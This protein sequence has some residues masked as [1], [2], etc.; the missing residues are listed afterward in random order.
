MFFPPI[1]PSAY[2]PP[3]P[4]R[5]LRDPIGPNERSL[6]PKGAHRGL[7]S[8]QCPPD[9]DRLARHSGLNNTPHGAPNCKLLRQ[10]TKQWLMWRDEAKMG[11]LR[12]VRQWHLAKP[13]ETYANCS[14]LP[15]KKV[16][17]KERRICMRETAK[18]PHWTYNASF[19]TSQKKGC[20]KNERGSF[21]PLALFV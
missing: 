14:T 21:F 18:V 15:A 5:N 1:S 11:P 8:S 3:P 2:P 17:L 12:G 16:L 9:G 10:F 6:A 4:P 20:I 13:C 7:P 19:L